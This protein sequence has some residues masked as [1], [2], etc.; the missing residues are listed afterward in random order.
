MEF[1]SSCV[2]LDGSRVEI[3]APHSFLPG[4]S[5]VGLAEM[6]SLERSNEFT[7]G[8]LELGRQIAESP[9]IGV[10]M[11]FNRELSL[12]GGRLLLAT[13]DQPVGPDGAEYWE[14]GPDGRGRQVALHFGIWEGV[15]HSLFTHIYGGEATVLVRVFEELKITEL[16]DGIVILPRSPGD[17]SYSEPVRILKDIPGA[18]LLDIKQLTKETA[19]G[20]PSA[21][22]TLVPGG[23]LY[24]HGHDE[25]SM[26]L[27]L[28]GD[29]A[30][31]HI[32]P[33]A[34][35]PLDQV[36]EVASSLVVTWQS[37]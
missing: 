15:H 30:V 4:F 32:I 34:G 28:A 3:T 8:L 9:E 10:G 33:H 31:T 26:W 2:A 35:D 1:R 20:I 16:E 29:S 12:D 37:G 14:I 36:L 7:A 27:L 17:L 5:S 19:R 25:G 18:S 22:G 6:R 13:G 23:E 24:V 21:A 11:T